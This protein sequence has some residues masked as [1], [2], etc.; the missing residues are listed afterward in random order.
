MWIRAVDTE[1][2]MARSSRSREPG[3]PA[4]TTSKAA[5]VFAAKRLRALGT[6]PLSTRKDHAALVQLPL[7]C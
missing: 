4:P 3:R 5:S 2:S 6:S 1:P 7:P